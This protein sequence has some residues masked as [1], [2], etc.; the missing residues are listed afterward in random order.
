MRKRIISALRVV[1]FISI[2]IV[3]Y[4]ATAQSTGQPKVHLHETPPPQQ[5][6]TSGGALGLSLQS[7]FSLL[8]GE[9]QVLMA[10]EIVDAS[11]DI[12]GE[13]Y[14]AVVQELE[15]PWTVVYLID[16]SKTLGG[17]ATGATFKNVKNIL[18]TSVEA[19]PVNSNISVMSFAN[20]AP[21]AMEFTQDKE[22]A[23]DA[24][25]NLAASGSGNSC[26]NDGLYEAVNKLTG[27]PGRKAVILFT[28]SADDCAR[29]TPQ[30][31]VDLAQQNQ[32]QIYPVGL[33]GY[34]ITKGELDSLAGPTGGVADLRDESA[35]SF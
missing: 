13:S 35:L 7:S 22:A 33:Q 21:T 16:T 29:R 11:Y 17:F 31:V 18:A 26:M 19:I 1:I 14:A 34:S 4:I 25:R 5:V 2:L 3:P 8:D 28:A 27:A 32:V 23:T 30:E 10:F 15:V 24:I 20:E 6:T 9:D 12:E